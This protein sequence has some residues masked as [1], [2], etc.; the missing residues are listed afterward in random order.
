MLQRYT[1]DEEVVKNSLTC[2]YNRVTILKQNH[3]LQD[4]LLPT[5]RG[6]VEYHVE[7]RVILHAL[8]QYANDD[9]HVWYMIKDKLEEKN[10]PTSH[11]SWRV[12]FVFLPRMVGG[13]Q[14]TAEMIHKQQMVDTLY[15]IFGAH[16]VSDGFGMGVIARIVVCSE[17]T[18]Y[19]ESRIRTSNFLVERLIQSQSTDTASI[20]LLTRIVNSG[21]IAI[22]R[23][24]SLF[25]LITRNLFHIDPARNSMSVA[26]DFYLCTQFFSSIFLKGLMTWPDADHAIKELANVF[27]MIKFVAIGAPHQSGGIYTLD[28][29]YSNSIGSLLGLICLD[30]KMRRL[31]NAININ[32]MFNAIQGVSGANLQAVMDSL[33][34]FVSNLKLRGLFYKY[35]Y[36]Q[37][38]CDLDKR[39]PFITGQVRI[40][41]DA[42]FPNI[43]RYRKYHDVV[44]V[45]K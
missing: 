33:L 22:M 43:I 42:M 23:K 12:L 16:D 21:N 32:P 31:V 24:S 26:K 25:T 19:S 34:P 14:K 28:P 38:I 15:E 6:V 27:E 36:Y 3:L 35:K 9:L 2:L 40:E 4:D 20:A 45:F 44:F 10:I 30:K 5:F 8:L 17:L 1:E 7:K 39:F 29:L 13:D 11:P 18:Y 37:I 41:Y